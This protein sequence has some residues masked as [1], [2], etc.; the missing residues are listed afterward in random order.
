[1]DRNINK[2]IKDTVFKDY[3]ETVWVYL[4]KSNSKGS[5]YDPFL[6]TGHTSTNQSP[7]PVKAHVRQIRP[8]SL[9][10]REIGLTESGAIELVIDSSDENLFRNCQ[11][12]KYNDKEYSPL[13]KALGDRVQIFRSPFNFSRVI[14]FTQ[15]T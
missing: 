11:K 13:I 15:G 7:E 12:V 6:D 3:A 8:N 2:R 5:D 10:A 9:V 1:M 4:K 14:L